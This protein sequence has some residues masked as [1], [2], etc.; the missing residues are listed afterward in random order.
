MAL[1][2]MREQRA[3][4]LLDALQDDLRAQMRLEKDELGRNGEN[5]RAS[6]RR[7]ARIARLSDPHERERIWSH[8]QFP[9]YEGV[10]IRSLPKTREFWREVDVSVW[11]KAELDAACSLLDLPVNGK[12]LDLVARIQDWVHEPE[13]RARLEEQRLL[14]LQQDAVLASGRVFAFGANSN[15]ELGLGHRRACEVP[16]EIESF[17]GA[18][19]THVYSG[20]DANFAFARSKD[21]QVFA[22]GGAGH[23]VFDE[24]AT[25]ADK[26]QVQQQEQEHQH[27]DSLDENST[28]SDGR[29]SC[30]LFP[31][32]ISSITNKNLVHLACGRTNGHIAITSDKGECFTWGRGEYG[33]LGTSEN[34]SKAITEE[35]LLV[36]TL[37]KFHVVTV[38]VGNTHT[39]AITDKGRLYTWG[40]CWSGQL[41]LGEA[42]RAGVKDKRLQLCFPIPTI[43]EAL[44]QKRITRVSCG[45]V[46]TAVVSADGQL[47]TFGCGD[48]GRLGL[49]GNEDSFHPQLVSA[50]EKC[51]VLDACCGSW[52][53]LCIARERDETFPVR[54]PRRVLEA[55]STCSDSTGGFVY[56]FGSGLQGQ[57]GLGKQKL[58]ALPN[59]NL[60]TWGQNTSGSLGRK[61]SD[62]GATDLPEPGVVDRGSFRN[63]GVGPIVSIAA[64]HG[65]TLFATGPWEPREEPS[66]MQFQLQTTVNRN[67]KQQQV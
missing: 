35:P 65:F 3:M 41:G 17:R 6:V 20:F 27:K 58:A 43:V 54:P 52:H 23:A 26:S 31:R 9:S 19:V 57:L 22:W 25:K 14:E 32:S 7:K 33:E 63:Y 46:H 39:A 49:G 8:E 60:Y 13:I 1:D 47:F 51:V 61:G 15:G 55:T 11:R 62:V 66:K 30:F 67:T 34:G 28:R 16:T 44:Q 38:S 12:K 5:R 53:T 40:S 21:G 59:G 50:L 45:A 18:H 56:S 2:R 36:D 64:G 29:G 37:R 48:G 10:A 4:K 42:K 24:V